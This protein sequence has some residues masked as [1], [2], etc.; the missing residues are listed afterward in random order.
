[1]MG[2][3]FGILVRNIVPFGIIALLVG[4][5][6]N[7]IVALLVS[8]EPAG[9]GSFPEAGGALPAPDWDLAVAGIIVY[10]VFS[11]FLTATLIYGAIQDLR[12]ERVSIAACLRRA[13]AVILPVIG[14]AILVTLAIGVGFVLLIVPGLIVLVMYFVAMPVAVVEQPGVFASLRRSAELT[15]GHRWTV[16]F[17]FVLIAV[18]QIVIGVVLELIPSLGFTVDVVIETVV[19]SFI[20][21]WY[22]VITAV[23]YFNLRYVKEGVDIDQ[24]AAVFD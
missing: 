3:A 7:A 19:Q 15:K 2:P 22:A 14:V 4:G 21:A 6:P 16:F 20:S 12:G 17:V 24:I 1:M 10:V 23:A 11:Y 8:A 5:V 18:V 9:A 13:L